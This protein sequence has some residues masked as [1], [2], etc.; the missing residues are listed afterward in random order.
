MNPSI[1]ILFIPDDI[2]G[3]F[4]FDPKTAIVKPFIA[5][6]INQTLK[7]IK[8]ESEL[9]HHSDLQKLGKSTILRDREKSFAIVSEQ[10]DSQV[11]PLSKT[12]VAASSLD[13]QME[14]ERQTVKIQ[15]SQDVLSFKRITAACSRV[16]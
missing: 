2:E 3:Q 15:D 12:I 9:F 7:Q 16:C 5:N 4:V 10:P 8:T 11:G 6:Y 13:G 1:K 14:A